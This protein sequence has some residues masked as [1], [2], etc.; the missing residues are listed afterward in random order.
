MVSKVEKLRDECIE[1]LNKASTLNW[2][3][4][5]SETISMNFKTIFRPLS[6]MPR[7]QKTS[8]LSAITG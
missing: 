1:K 8:L 3:G 7:N 4:G 5:V 6:L 2:F